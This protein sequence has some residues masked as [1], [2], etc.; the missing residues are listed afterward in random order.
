MEIADTLTP[1]DF[2]ISSL[3]LFPRSRINRSATTA[4]SNYFHQL[5][6]RIADRTASLTLKHQDNNP[7]NNYNKENYTC[8]EFHYLFQHGC[9]SNEHMIECKRI[10]GFLPRPRVTSDFL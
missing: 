6:P 1:T 8:N 2:A 3:L 7:Y 10:G 4:L 5:S 9:I